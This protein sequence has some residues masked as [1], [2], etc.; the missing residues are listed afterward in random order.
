MS[1]EDHEDEWEP[2]GA[3]HTFKGYEVKDHGVHRDTLNHGTQDPDEMN[4]DQE[5]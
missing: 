4:L 3:N 2:R 1:H 5:E